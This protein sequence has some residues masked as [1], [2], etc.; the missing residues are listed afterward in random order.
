MVIPADRHKYLLE[1]PR[2]CISAITSSANGKGDKND[3]PSIVSKM[4][5]SEADKVC[6]K[7]R[8]S[9]Q[10]ANRAVRSFQCSVE[11]AT[12][13]TTTTKTEFIK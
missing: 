8:T 7:V 4:P 3:P 6:S 11:C 10:K 13:T 12:T 2:F 1:V 5:L 9:G